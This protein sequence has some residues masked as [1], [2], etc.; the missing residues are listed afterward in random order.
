M[1]ISEKTHAKITNISILIIASFLIFRK[2]ATLMI[3]FFIFYNL[4][5]LKKL[6]ICKTSILSQIIVYLPL[7]IHIMFLWHNKDLVLGLKDVE[8]YICLLVLPIFIV[9]NFKYMKINI[10]LENYSILFCCI[11]TFLFIKYIITAPDLFAEYQSGI[12]QWEMGYSFAKTFNTHAPALNMHVAFATSVAFYFLIENL[13][14]KVSYYKITVNLVVLF[15]L[16]YYLLYINTRL[17]LVNVLFSIVI[18]ISFNLFVT[19]IS[20]KTIITCFLLLTMFILSIAFFVVKNPYMVVKYTVVT[21]DNFD[22][23]GRLDEIDNVQA[24]A[25]NS[26]VTRISIWISTCELIAAKPILGYGSSDSKETLFNYYKKTN[27]QFLFKN[28]FPVHNQFLDF[29]LKFGFLGF[30]CVFV[31]MVNILY[32]G[33]VLRNALVITFFCIFFFSNLTDDFLIRFDGIVFSGFW[34]SCFVCLHKQFTQQIK[35]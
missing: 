14:L 3:M 11:L 13:K 12:H 26:L 9:G 25:C 6:Q 30:M 17:A 15:L 32:I 4:F 29:T 34:I 1:I 27:Q 22:K 33:I 31:F 23:I 10:I 24:V 28:K 7:L 19:K 20:K 2:P 21:F 5:N 8:K 16:F 18:I 35:I